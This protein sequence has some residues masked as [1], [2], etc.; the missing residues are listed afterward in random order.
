MFF[1][2]FCLLFYALFQFFIGDVLALGFNSFWWFTH[3]VSQVV[4]CLKSQSKLLTLSNYAN[5]LSHMVNIKTLKHFHFLQCN[6]C[7]LGMVLWKMVAIFFYKIVKTWTLFNWYSNDTFLPLQN[8]TWPV[9]RKI[10]DRQL[11]VKCY[12]IKMVKSPYNWVIFPLT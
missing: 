4:F 6:H 10:A 12:D 3:V 9:Y 5:L 11:L 2:K 8:W 7:S 1:N